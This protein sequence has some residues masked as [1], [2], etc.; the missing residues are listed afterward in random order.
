MG[1]GVHG[2]TA[3][4][5]GFDSAGNELPGSPLFPLGPNR[6]PLANL[7]L[8]LARPAAAAA[9]TVAAE[10]SWPTSESFTFLLPTAW[11]TARTINLSA[12]LVPARAA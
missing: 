1:D 8:I 10:R 2:V 11:T 6:V 9:A 4:L 3:M 12:Q 5:N 7:S